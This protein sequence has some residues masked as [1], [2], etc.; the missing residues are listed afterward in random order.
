MS[1]RLLVAD[2]HPVAVAGVRSFVAGTEIAVVA[3]ARDGRKAVRLATEAS[4]D[5]VLMAVG[6]PKEDGLGALTRIKQA[7]PDLP[8]VMTGCYDH[9]AHLAQAH[10][11]GASGF[12]LKDFSRQKLLDTLRQVAAGE[13]TWSRE[14]IRRVTGVL[15]A[16]RLTAALEFPLTSRER[17]VLQ[18]VTG[19]LTNRQIAEQ[20]GISYE[21]VKEHVQNI[22]HKIGVADRTQAAVWAVRSG[23]A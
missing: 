4:P 3:E 17:D 20:L 13:E 18:R 15:T 8:V 22:I 19:G 7:R 6:L 23:L 9:P 5:V 21:T 16:G 1:T 10:K 14:E 2:P 12:L 11:R